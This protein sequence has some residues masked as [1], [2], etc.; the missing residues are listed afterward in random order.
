MSLS[1]ELTLESLGAA[2]LSGDAPACAVR[3]VDALRRTTPALLALDDAATMRRP[4]PG[5]W[6]PREIIGHLVDSASNNHQR[7]VRMRE[8]DE[9]VVEGYEQDEWVVAQR[10]Q[11]APWTELVVLWMTYNRHLARLMAATPAADRDRVRQRHN[12][13][14]RAYRPMPADRA[15][16]LGYFMNDYVEHLEHHLAQVLG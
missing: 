3:L 5:K 2:P 12:L 6:S 16:T 9:L 14:L 8:R 1:H 15:V 13:H 11:D 4:A 10:Y 7:F